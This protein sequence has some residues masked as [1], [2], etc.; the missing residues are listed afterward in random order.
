M[1]DIKQPSPLN[2][3]EDILPYL[4]PGTVQSAQHCLHS[5]LG[6]IILFA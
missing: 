1:N 5:K 6:V 4:Y 3:K 2:I